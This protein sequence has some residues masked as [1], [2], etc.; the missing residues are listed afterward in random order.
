MF[1]NF[2]S[3]VQ[4]KNIVSDTQLTLKAKSS[5]VVFSLYKNLEV[6]VSD[7][8]TPPVNYDCKNVLQNWTQLLMILTIYNRVTLSIKLFTAVS[9]LSGDPLQSRLLASPINI[10][11][12]W[13]GLQGTN[14]LTCYENPQLTAVKSFIVQAPG[15]N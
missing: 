10:R 5:K 12:A 2:R 4:F 7:K 15:T 11:L 14:T 8:F 3:D 6:A 1:L 13:K 9:Y